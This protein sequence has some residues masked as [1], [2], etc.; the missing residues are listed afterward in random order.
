[1]DVPAGEKSVMAQMVEVY[2]RE[3]LSVLAVQ[4]VP[5]ADTRQYGIVSATE[6]QPGLERVN[7]I[8][9]KPDPDSAPSTLAVVGRYVLTNRIFECIENLEKGAGGEIQLTDGI[10]ALMQRESVLA[11][12]YKGQRFDCGSKLGYLKA[13]VEMG[14]RHPET[15]EGMTRYLQERQ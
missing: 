9:E 6:Y 15:G 10:A 14:L 3:G 1:M 7:A 8:V 11:Y 5:R 13:T 2:E 4:D 12:R